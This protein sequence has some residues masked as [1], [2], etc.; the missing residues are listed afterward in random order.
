MELFRLE[1]DPATGHHREATGHSHAAPQEMTRRVEPLLCSDESR[2]WR[3]HDR[4]LSGS[5]T[6]TTRL[7]SSSI[8]SLR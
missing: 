7:I 3:T 6:P 8:A 4:P 5:A 1:L 2:L